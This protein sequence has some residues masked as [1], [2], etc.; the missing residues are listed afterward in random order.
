[1]TAKADPVGISPSFELEQIEADIGGVKGAPLNAAEAAAAIQ[2]PPAA[3]PAVKPKRKYE[4]QPGSDRPGPKG[5]RIK[6]DPGPGSSAKPLASK[7]ADPRTKA[8]IAASEAHLKSQL[9][10]VQGGIPTSEEEQ[11]AERVLQGVM[12][13][14]EGVCYA[15]D[16]PAASPT[17]KEADFF[18]SSGKRPLAPYLSKLGP[19]ADFGPFIVAC[20]ALGFGGY[21]RQMEANKKK[22]MMERK[23]VE[24]AKPLAQ[25]L[26]APITPHAIQE[27]VEPMVGPM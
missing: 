25:E 22:A 17:L 2:P 12:V 8:E 15:I 9:A 10:A 27:P 6:I 11:Q 18:V 20:L 7:N 13:S 14:V 23:P 1:M 3:A 24:A 5:P 4:K 21:K 19:G 16:M 26:T